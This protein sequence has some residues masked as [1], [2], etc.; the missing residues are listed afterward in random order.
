MDVQRKG[1]KKRKTIVTVIVGILALAGLTVAW[2]WAKN[3]KR[4]APGVE[5]S[6]LWPDTV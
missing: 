1:V 5:L 6:T 2:K 4:A 3:L